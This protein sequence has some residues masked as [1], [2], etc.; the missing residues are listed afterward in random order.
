MKHDTT[1]PTGDNQ[2]YEDRLLQLNVF[3]GDFGDGM[4]Q[5]TRSLV[6]TRKN[7]T[8]YTCVLPIEKGELCR[9]DKREGRLTA[10]H[11][12]G[13]LEKMLKHAGVIA[14]EK[15]DVLATG[16]SRLFGDRLKKAMWIHGMTQAEFARKSGVQPMEI[17]HWVN[18]RRE[19][20]RANLAKLIRALPRTRARWLIAG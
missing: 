17:N 18:G 6:T 19:P 9:V 10:Y 16:D 15:E 20:S 13:C 3:E 2:S 11:C 8:C 1:A 4:R 7:H 12:I 5:S 14:S